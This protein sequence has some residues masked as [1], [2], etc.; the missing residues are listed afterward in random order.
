MRPSEGQNREPLLKRGIVAATAAASLCLFMRGDT[1][2]EMRHI[3][4]QQTTPARRDSEQR[5][6][7][8]SFRVASGDGAEN[9]DTHCAFADDGLTLLA[10]GAEFR[11][12]HIQAGNVALPQDRIRSW[13]GDGGI[14]SIAMNETDITFHSDTGRV[15]IPRTDLQRIIETLRTNATADVP[16]VHFALETDSL[17]RF[18]INTDGICSVRFAV[19]ASRPAATDVAK[20]IDPY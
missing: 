15:T 7:L 6:I 10:H 17:L 3:F 19:Q 9:S 18:L 8:A 11:L 12:D 16:D 4:D 1:A 14:T 20:Q 2:Q 13:I 5:K